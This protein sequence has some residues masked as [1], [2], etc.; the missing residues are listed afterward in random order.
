MANNVFKALNSMRARLGIDQA[1]QPL[2]PMTVSGQV[3]SANLHLPTS[4]NLISPFSA[5]QVCPAKCERRFLKP[6]PRW[7][8]VARRRQ[9]AHV[10]PEITLPQNQLPAGVVILSERAAVQSRILLHLQFEKEHFGIEIE[11]NLSVPQDM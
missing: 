9:T 4:N 11:T 7:K 1:R 10:Q 2:R 5:A 6:K 8:K 3:V